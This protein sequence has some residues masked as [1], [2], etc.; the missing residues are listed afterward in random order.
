MAPCD[1]IV[2]E[3]KHWTRWADSEGDLLTAVDF[4]DNAI[5]FVYGT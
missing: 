4:I 1:V 3:K 2:V 5:L